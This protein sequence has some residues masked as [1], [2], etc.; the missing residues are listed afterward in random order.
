MAALA[1]IYLEDSPEPV[2]VSGG[3]KSIL[4]IRKTITNNQGAKPQSVIQHIQFKNQ[5]VRTRNIAMATI[6]DPTKKMRNFTKVLL[7]NGSEVKLPISSG[8]VAEEIGKKYEDDL[9]KSNFIDD[10]WTIVRKVSIKEI[11]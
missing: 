2:V 7:I 6:H 3:Q 9:Y 1:F 5:I 11:F 8:V 4:K 10:N